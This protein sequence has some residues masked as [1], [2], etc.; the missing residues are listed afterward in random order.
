MSEGF[1]L[2]TNV[3]SELTKSRIEPRVQSWVAAQDFGSLLISVVS[4]GE[5]EK[6]F[7]MMADPSRRVRLR[8]WLERQLVELFRGQVLPVSQAIAERWGVLDGT[9]QMAGRPV[10]APD[11]M[12]AATALEH[13]LTVVTRN[14][15]DFEGLGVVLIN[16]WLEL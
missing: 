12:I 14:T 10:N 9:R 5:I 8:V 7:T 3:V 4:I 11:G 2:D 13:D 6:G 15:R 16:P 1:L